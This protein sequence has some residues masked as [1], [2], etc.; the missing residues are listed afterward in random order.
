MMG[1]LSSQGG[2]FSGDQ[3]HMDHVGRNTFY[4]WLGTEGPRVFPDEAF[5]DFYVLD[6]GRKSVPPS[7][8]IRMVLL[9]WFAQVSDD[10]AIERAKFDLRWK[11][12]LG[13]EDHSGLC[14]KF[15]L[16]TFRGKLLLSGK[17][18]DLLKR[19]VKVCREKGVLRSRKVR[20]AQQEGSPAVYVPSPYRSSTPVMATRSRNAHG[21]RTGAVHLLTFANTLPPPPP[22]LPD[23]VVLPQRPFLP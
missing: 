7:Q 11:V 21:R 13:L 15:T 18:R 2:L 22:P 12:A 1:E 14:A 9:Q 5:R 19:S 20:A 8:M 23:P 17:G 10:Q 6:N 3:L 4:G 16:Q